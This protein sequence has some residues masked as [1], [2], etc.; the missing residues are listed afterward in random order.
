MAIGSVVTPAL[1]SWLGPKG[2]LIAAGSLLPILLIW[3]WP[4]LRRIDAEL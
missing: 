1:V 3:L 2:A 4:S